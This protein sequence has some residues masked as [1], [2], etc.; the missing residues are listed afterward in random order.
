MSSLGLLL[1]TGTATAQVVATG[2]AT[3]DGFRKV[4]L[5]SRYYSESADVGDFN[6]DGKLDV[7]SGPFWYEGPAFA[8]RHTIYK[9]IAFP[10]TS[11]ADQF[12]AMTLDVNRDGWDDVVSI[13][14]PSTPARWFENPRKAA[15]SWTPHHLA[16]GIGNESP[17]LLDLVGD[18][19]RELVSFG[20]GRVGY[21]TPDTS[22]ATRPWIF[23]SIATLTGLSPFIHGLGVGDLNG[24]GRKDYI[25]AYGWFEQPKSL[26]NDPP[27]TFHFARLGS[28]AGGSQME[29][30][31]VD[32]DGDLDVIASMHAHGYGLSWFENTVVGK[33]RVFR[34]HVILSE[35]KNGSFPVQF[36]QL[37][38]L[39]LADMDGDGLADI[40]TGKTYWAH[41]GTDPGANDGAV[42]YW[43]KLSRGRG[44]RFLPRWISNDTGIGRRLVVRD[45]NGDGR[46]DV[47]IGNKLGAAVLFQH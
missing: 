1:I 45:M 8:K 18:A 4:A 44:I 26:T 41:N 25:T 40:V 16:N 36:S 31:D 7:V 27:W 35:A 29:A 2:T 9:P 23:H 38:G 21:F 13:G 28:L 12:F 46:R 5:A 11:F 30:Y 39:A 3:V 15:T 37:H 19:R 6:R 24:D 32:G 10:R 33:S 22:G 14:G 17:R 42:I 20:S 34:Q 47:V 43:F